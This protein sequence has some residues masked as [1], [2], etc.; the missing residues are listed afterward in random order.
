MNQCSKC[1]TTQTEKWYFRK[2]P[3]ILCKKC[4]DS[5]RHSIYSKKRFTYKGERIRTKDFPRTGICSVCGFEGKTE[6]HH[7]EYDDNNP[8][9]NTIEVCKSCHCRRAWELGQYD[10]K[11]ENFSII[12]KRDN[13]GRFTK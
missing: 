12:M 9:S 3:E 10:K 13:K 1:E 6:L 2:S 7:E 4:Y 5:K 8:I 11:M